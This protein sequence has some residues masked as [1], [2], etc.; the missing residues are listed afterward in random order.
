MWAIALCYG[1]KRHQLGFNFQN[2]IRLNV[3]LM[4]ARFET[5]C[6]AL[7]KIGACL[8]P[9]KGIGIELWTK[10]TKYFAKSFMKVFI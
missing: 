8:Q 1:S 7:T 6:Q 4:I 9:Q 5:I 3:N 10:H 2:E